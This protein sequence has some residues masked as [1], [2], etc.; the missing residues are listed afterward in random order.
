MRYLVALLI[1]CTFVYLVY[2]F[3]SRDKSVSGDPA[4]VGVSQ[5]AGNGDY[6]VDP[7]SAYGDDSD[8]APDPDTEEEDFFTDDQDIYSRE[9]FQKTLKPLSRKKKIV[10]AFRLAESNPF[11]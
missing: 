6:Q 10:W 7:A 4:G 1:F 11:L 2:T 3:A 8:N 5:E 9:L